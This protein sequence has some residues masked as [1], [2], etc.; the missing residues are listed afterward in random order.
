MTQRL[1]VEGIQYGQTQELDISQPILVEILGTDWQKYSLGGGRFRTRRILSDAEVKAL[2]TGGFPLVL[3]EENH[4][5]LPIYSILRLIHTANYTNIAATC[6]LDIEYASTAVDPYGILDE[7]I[8]S[9]VTVLLAGGGDTMSIMRLRDI[10]SVAL[11]PDATVGRTYDSGNLADMIGEGLSIFAFNAA[12]GA[13]TGGDPANKLI[14]DTI[15]DL[16][17]LLN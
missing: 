8:G 1:T 2:P 12:S 4:L 7:T 13:F 5:V 6:I 3:G 9:A 17:P 10:V 15:Y 16:I 11:N 14:I